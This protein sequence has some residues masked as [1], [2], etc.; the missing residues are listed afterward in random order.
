MPVGAAW[1]AIQPD[2][3]FPGILLNLDTLADDYELPPGSAL[4]GRPGSPHFAIRETE[5]PGW[6]RYAVSPSPA[7][8]AIPLP[9]HFAGRLMTEGSGHVAINDA[10]DFAAASGGVGL[11]VFDPRKPAGIRRLHDWRCFDLDVGPDRRVAFAGFL[12]S[13]WHASDLPEAEARRSARLKGRGSRVSVAEESGI[14]AVVNT[15]RELRIYRSDGGEIPVP[16]ALAGTPIQSAELHP[17][18]SAIAAL[19]TGRRGIVVCALPT[20]EEIG[21][22]PT[23]RKMPPL[24]FAGGTL[25]VIGD[26][27]D[28]AC[29][30]YLAGTDLW[31]RPHRIKERRPALAAA[32]WKAD[33][34]AITL[35]N[36]AIQLIDPRTGAD[37][38]PPLALPEPFPLESI[39]LDASGRHCAGLGG[40]S[41]LQV[42][43]LR[44]L[45][46]KLSE[47]GIPTP[48]DPTPREDR[49]P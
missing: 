39:A 34:A 38:L 12:E 49:K 40:G 27:N 41:R 30:D 22:R 4:A 28:Y 9:G 46:R 24:A 19:H 36:R 3:G 48:P 13:Y 42:W 47:L 26:L 18:G 23:E 5:R 32:A 10:G 7:V 35:D 44:V 15:A 11:C 31:K 21:F 6:T 14:M 17:D 33:L 25:L 1:L 2:W 16:P 45:R 37:A 8:A 29:W 20:G 43:D